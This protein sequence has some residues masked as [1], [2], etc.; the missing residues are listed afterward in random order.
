MASTLTHTFSTPTLGTKS[1]ISM[2]IKRSDIGSDGSIFSTY[3]DSNNT[4]T[5]LDVDANIFTG[6]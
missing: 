1:T 6:I 4:Q 3:T 5:S 2:W